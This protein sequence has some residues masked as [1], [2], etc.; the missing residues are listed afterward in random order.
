MQAVNGNVATIDSALGQSLAVNTE[1]QA[2]ILGPKTQH[3]IGS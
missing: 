3:N 2:H 1:L